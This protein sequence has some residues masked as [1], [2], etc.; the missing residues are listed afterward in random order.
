MKRALVLALLLLPT[1]ALAAP[2]SYTAAKDLI[3]A[4]S[5]TGNSYLAGGSVTVSAPVTGDLTAVSGTFVLGAPVNGDALFL[6]GIESVRGAITGD[7][8]AAGGRVSIESPVSGD[9]VVLAGSM[10]DSGAH[11]KS[12]FVIAGTALLTAGSGGDTTVYANNVTLG[13]TF[14]GDVHVVAG[15]VLT[16]SPGTK[17]HGALTY[18]A[19]ESSTIPADAVI[20]GGVHYTG[21]SYLPSSQETRA[22]ALASFGIFLFVKVL[23]ALILAGLIAGLFPEVARAVADRALARRAR[24]VLL[25]TLLGFA[26]IVATPVLLVL[27]A[28]TF[29]GL[30]VA[31]LVGLVYALVLVI[32]FAMSGVI[33]GSV[34]ARRFMH[35][36]SVLWHDA[37]IGMLIIS[38]ITFVPIFGRALVFLLIAFSVGAL[39]ALFYRHAFPRDTETPA[40]L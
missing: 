9:E 16:V 38:L 18:Q 19:P 29:V 6:G 1:G 36:E 15:S 11:A 13:G 40:L 2:S 25:T 17:I 35:R 10:S 20:D 28:I 3:V 4:S 23:G 21:A 27:L 14:A 7:L 24:S 33:I 34:L 12:V 32:S 37:V 31:L 8:R 22:I 30:G 5:T 39:S 26:I